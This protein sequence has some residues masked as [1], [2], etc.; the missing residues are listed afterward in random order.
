LALYLENAEIQNAAFSLISVGYEFENQAQPWGEIANAYILERHVCSKKHTFFFQ[1]SFLVINPPK[2]L[3]IP[4]QRHFIQLTAQTVFT[5][6]FNIE[7]S[8]L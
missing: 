4:Y 8:I 6:F 7:P 2:D 1:A 3:T 5:A